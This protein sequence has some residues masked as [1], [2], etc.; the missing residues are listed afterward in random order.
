MSTFQTLVDRIREAAEEPDPRGA[1]RAV[2]GD[3]LEEAE[4]LRGETPPDGPDEINLYEDDR[5]SIWRSRFQPDVLMPA[6]EHQ[7]PVL[8]ACYSGAEK[9]LLYARNGE[10][11][12][13]TGTVIAKEGEI[14]ELPED[15]IHKVTAEGTRP[16]EALHVYFGPLTRL[17]RAL[18]DPESGKTLPFTMANFEA[19][20]QSTGNAAG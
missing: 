5:V 20:K 9:S 11:L 16:S 4:A 6:H 12:Q 3:A 13:Q 2:L 10:V 15:A 18:F 17:D 19:L 7:V 14:I 8:I 1:V